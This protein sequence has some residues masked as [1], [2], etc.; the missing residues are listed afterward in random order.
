MRLM[1]LW[2]LSLVTSLA[3]FNLHPRILVS[4]TLTSRKLSWT[5]DCV[6]RN[7]PA[8]PLQR[9]P[10]HNLLLLSES[11]CKRENE[12]Q[13]GN[14]CFMPVFRRGPANQPSGAKH[15]RPECVGFMARGCLCCLC[16]SCSQLCGA[17]A[18]VP[19]ALPRSHLLPVPRCQPLPVIWGL[20][21]W[22]R[23]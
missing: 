23:D 18:S 8:N 21:F 15:H 19:S 14:L 4:K 1:W 5:G 13:K 3:N 16:S 17:R 10:Q 9:G 12:G 11:W 22:S 6:N 7:Y 20:L 2:C